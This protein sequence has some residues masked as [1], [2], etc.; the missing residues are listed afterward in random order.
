MKKI[1]NFYKEYKLISEI[2]FDQEQKDII[3]FVEYFA[4]NK[5]NIS[6]VGCGYG[7]I[8]NKIKN[9]ITGFDISNELLI[10][11]KRNN[12]N[13]IYYQKDFKEKVSS[14]FINRF[15][16]T[17]CMRSSFGVFEGLN[18]NIKFLDNLIKITNKNGTIILDLLNENLVRNYF[19]D[20]ISYKNNDYEL[21][22]LSEI[23]DN[24]L[25]QNWILKK[26]KKEILNNKLGQY[27]FSPEFIKEYLKN[28]GLK[29]KNIY[30]DYNFNSYKN[31]S[32][33]KILEIKKC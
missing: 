3:K 6:D 10:H 21:I 26:E 19:K 28:K 33:R 20:S 23:K 29:I 9:P 30:G 31:N 27:L 5:N 22:R 13:N 14:K 25:I 2:F 32:K 15:D 24:Y 8:S 1:K 17:I 12:N 7:F 11:A 16:L 4:E 18:D